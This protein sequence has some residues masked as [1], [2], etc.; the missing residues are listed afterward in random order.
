MMWLLSGWT[1]VTGNPDYAVRS[2]FKTG[3]DYSIMADPKKL[4]NSLIKQQPK[5]LKSTR[6][7]TSN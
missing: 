7:H 6:R 2:V 3:G 5:L 4:T 1:T